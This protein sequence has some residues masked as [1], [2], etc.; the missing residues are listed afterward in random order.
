VICITGNDAIY[1]ASDSL[2]TP[3]YGE[4]FRSPK[5]FCV[6]NS[7]CFYM[8][9]FGGAC[10]KN[11]TTGKVSSSLATDLQEICA[12]VSVKSDPIE[13]RVE[14]V[15]SQFQ[16]KHKESFNKMISAGETNANGIT[17]VGVMGY[18][19]SRKFFFGSEYVFDGTNASVTQN[20]IGNKGVL[21]NAGP[22]TFTGENNF[23]SSLLQDAKLMRELP[24]DDFRQTVQDIWM[25]T[26][27][28]QE[29][30]KSCILEMFTLQEKHAIALRYDQHV[31]GGPYVIYKITKDKTIEIN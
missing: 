22:F 1:V 31:I 28:S 4:P 29:R 13:M 6:S 8:T 7:C 17:H 23:L 15:I 21:T 5:I 12:S 10:I 27:V 20:N 2:V 11:A 25:K 24:S 3:G 14:D 18:S 30:M 19:D 26:T 16:S 9:G